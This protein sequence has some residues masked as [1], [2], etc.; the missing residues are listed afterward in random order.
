MSG[1]IVESKP[2][3]KLEICELIG[4]KEPSV[5]NALEALGVTPKRDLADRRRLVYP[6]GTAQRVKEWL[7]TH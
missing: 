4:A 5:E 7:E 1:N 6:V 3:T 2:L